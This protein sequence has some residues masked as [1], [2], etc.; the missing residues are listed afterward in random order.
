MSERTIGADEADLPRWRALAFL[1]L[2][3][4]GAG[5]LR[6]S[7]GI[8]KSLGFPAK[9]AHKE[10]FVDWLDGTFGTRFADALDA[11]EAKVA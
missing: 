1:L 11:V 8:T 10:A 5:P 7:R 6:K 2:T 4:K 9:T 3:E